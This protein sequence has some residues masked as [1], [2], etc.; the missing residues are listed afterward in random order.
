MPRHFAQEA[1]LGQRTFTSDDAKRGLAAFADEG[2][3]M[4]GEHTAY[5]CSRP[6]RRKQQGDGLRIGLT[7]EL[8]VFLVAVVLFVYFSV[9]LDNFLSSANILNLIRN[10]AMLGMLSLGMAVS[11]SAGAWISRSLPSWRCR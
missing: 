6:V 4:R 7:Q 5:P 10:V 8:I 3:M 9:T 1:V 11:S 2:Q